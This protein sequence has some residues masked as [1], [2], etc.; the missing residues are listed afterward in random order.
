MYIAKTRLA[1]HDLPVASCF[2]DVSYAERRSAVP[3][4]IV[5]CSPSALA[6]RSS[7]GIV[8]V[9]P[10]ASKRATPGLRHAG[11]FG[12]LPLG[13]AEFLPPGAHRFNQLE[14]QPGLLISFRCRWAFHSG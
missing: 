9:V 14:T 3:R 1:A 13:Q 7:T 2:D 4:E 6:R 12:E 10:P 5:S 11:P 8:G